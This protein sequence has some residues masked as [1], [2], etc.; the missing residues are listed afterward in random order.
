LPIIDTPFTTIKVTFPA[1]G[2]TE[3]LVTLALRVTDWEELAL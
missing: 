2:F 3:P 1:V